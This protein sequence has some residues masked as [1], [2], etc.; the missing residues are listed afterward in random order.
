MAS[1]VID[2]DQGCLV[3]T[4][5]LQLP[6]G[7]APRLRFIAFDFAFA[8]WSATLDTNIRYGTTDPLSQRAWTDREGA[9]ALSRP[10]P[11]G[12]GTLHLEILSCPRPCGFKRR[13]N[14]QC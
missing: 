11:R 6:A 10:L 14:M 7:L 8:T 9:I 1:I 12:M 5:E 13:D 3:V 4:V 2:P